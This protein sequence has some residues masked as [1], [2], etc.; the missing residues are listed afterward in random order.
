M[1]YPQETQER[2]RVSELKNE[3]I[4]LQ[5][6]TFTKWVNAFL[7]TSGHSVS[8]IFTDLSDGKLLITLVENISGAKLGNACK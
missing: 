8:D 2:D 7:E 3:R 6:K 4:T 1:D 5:K